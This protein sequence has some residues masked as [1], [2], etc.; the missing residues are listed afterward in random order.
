MAVEYIG[1]SG[2]D[3]SVVFKS[4]T[5]SYGAFYGATPIVQPADTS[6]SAVSTTALTTLTD[7]VTT[8]SVTGAFNSV[9]SRV[10]ALWV[11]ANRMRTDLV[12]LGLL[13]GSI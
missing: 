9:V 12:S 7:I 13:K 4:A 6:Q 8:A 10:T 1:D 3:G 5:L 11:L 2:P